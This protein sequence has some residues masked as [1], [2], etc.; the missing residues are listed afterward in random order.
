MCVSNNQDSNNMK[1]NLT[2]LNEETNQP[3]ELETPE[4]LT[5][6]LTETADGKSVRIQKTGET[7][8]INQHDLT[9]T[10]RNFPQRSRTH[11][12]LKDT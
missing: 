5:Q 10:Y 3:L 8:P 7:L 6:Q 2:K 12:L 1:Q 11:I 4:V 9:D